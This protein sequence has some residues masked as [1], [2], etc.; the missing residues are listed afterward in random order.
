MNTTKH[1]TQTPEYWESLA[2][3]ERAFAAEKRRNRY[4][5]V[6]G[7]RIHERQAAEYEANAARLRGQS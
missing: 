2:R 7:I 5:T 3:N 6:E 4:G 1:P